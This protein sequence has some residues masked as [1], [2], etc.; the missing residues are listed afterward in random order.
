MAIT[1][2]ALISFWYAFSIKPL[3]LGLFAGVAG[4]NGYLAALL[5]R[6]V[7]GIIIWKVIAPYAKT[8]RYITL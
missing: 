4:R 2:W 3:K 6:P 8:V 1:L 5:G 7:A